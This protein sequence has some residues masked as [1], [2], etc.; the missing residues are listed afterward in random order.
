MDPTRLDLPIRLVP[1]K[2][3]QIG[4]LLFF[5]VF[6]GFS[7]FWMAGAAGILDLNAGEIRWP[8]PGAWGDAAF[9][10]VGLP[11]TAIGLCGMAGALLKMRPNSPHYHIEI[12]SGGV[13]VKEL[14]SRRQH[15]WATLPGFETI[16]VERRTKNGK[17]TSYYTVA[18][19]TLSSTATSTRQREILR[20]RADDYGARN[21]MG[22]A[23]AMTAWFNQLREMARDNKLDAHQ[24]I[25]IPEPFRATAI[26]LGEVGGGISTQ[27]RGAA[28]QVGGG[29][30]ARRPTVDRQ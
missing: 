22:D 27:P 25:E 8:E 26:A 10:L 11:F 2:G 21:G 12:N 15:D 3:Q 7:L 14:F 18:T 20:I 29:N 24:A 13:M 1:R 30:A 16:K 19:E 28:R 4:M 6:F 17:S 23:D 5:A 9:A